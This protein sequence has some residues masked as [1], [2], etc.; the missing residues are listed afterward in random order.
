MTALAP[1]PLSGWTEAQLRTLQAAAA[2]AP[3]EPD[4]DELRDEVRAEL[5]RRGAVERATGPS[6]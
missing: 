2:N 3:R 5:E 6:A 4:C 1:Y